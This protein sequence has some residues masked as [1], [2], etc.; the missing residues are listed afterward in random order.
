MQTLLTCVALPQSGL[1][2]VLHPLLGVQRIHSNTPVAWA[3]RWMGR[4]ASPSTGAKTT[5]MR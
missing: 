1:D 5:S 2:F 3:M 4:T